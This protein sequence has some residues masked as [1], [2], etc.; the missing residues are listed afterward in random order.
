LLRR[1][2]GLGLG[3]HVPTFEN[4]L[5]LLRHLVRTGRDTVY[6]F[7]LR[8]AYRPE[9]FAHRRFDLVAGNPPWLSYRYVEDTA[10]QERVKRKAQAYGLV[11]SNEVRLFTQME[12]AT[13]F[14]AH[15]YE[16]YLRDGGAIAFVMPRSVLTGAQQHRRFRQRFDGSLVKV[17]DLEGVS[18]LFN[19]PAC[20]LI[21]RK[22]GK[23]APAP[24]VVALRGELPRKNA[25]YEEAQRC[26]AE[27]P[28][29]L[30]ALPPL[31][32]SP[33]RSRF[34]QGATIVPRTFWFVRPPEGALGVDPSRPSLETDPAVLRKAK[35]P[36]KELTMKGEV[37]AP[38]L[39]ATL[40]DDDL[41]PFGYRRLR[42]V[43]LPIELG[44]DGRARLV[45]KR[46]ALERGYAGLKEWLEKAEAL[47]EQHKSA[48]T[49]QSLLEWLNYQGKLIRQR[50]GA[51][52]VVYTRS[53]TYLTAAVVGV[54]SL[55]VC[56]LS[57][58]GFV[59]D[60]MLYSYEASDPHEAHYL[61][62]LLNAPCI[63]A[64]VKPFQTKGAFGARDFHRRPFE[65]LPDP[66]PPLRPPGQ[67]ASATR[68]ALKAVPPAGGR[69][70]ALPIQG[71][72]PPAPGG[73]GGPP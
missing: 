69:H 24:Q 73:A 14:F 53:G 6:A 8:N 35:P 68:R 62:A 64:A 49:E 3:S 21:A 27:E 17:L 34:V 51:L 2:E 22:D 47:W 37:E 12:L 7:V 59:V 54:K 30:P 45:D 44:P 66:I 60:N 52:R 38:F 13:L 5:R 16:R 72:R 20:V 28:A 40:L 19:V 46:Q 26:L 1:L 70:A 65:V 39:Y 4:A 42:L 18:P 63:D 25:S 33:Y 48:T 67:E 55:S 61:A 56:D 29:E 11:A 10:Y 50:P 23:E 43:V 9:L 57:V 36:W 41:V 58:A 31:K 15:S 71:H 32:P